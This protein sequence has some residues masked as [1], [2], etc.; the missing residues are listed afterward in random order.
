MRHLARIL[1]PTLPLKGVLLINGSMGSGKTF[2]CKHLIQA[3]QENEKKHVEDIPSPT[4]TLVQTYN[5]E[6]SEIW[7]CDFYRIKTA[8]ELLELG[9]EEGFENALCLIE[10]P[11]GLD[12]LEI[13][14]VANLEIKTGPNITERELIFVSESEKWR[15]FAKKFES[16]IF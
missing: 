2:L 10:W 13:F 7:H 4:F 14:D 12:N 1:A 8:S 5:F 16:I 6:N 9:L 3:K 15:A 11:K